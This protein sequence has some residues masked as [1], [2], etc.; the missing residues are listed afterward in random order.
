[1]NFVEIVGELNDELYN[2]FDELE[3]CFSYMTNAASDIIKFEDTI[4]WN[5]EEDDRKYDEEKED[6]EPFI[7]F[8]KQKF[9]DW[10][11][12]INSLKL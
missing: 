6:Y 7:P 4:L 10:A 5:S 1:M 2:E 12:K 8:I 11:D 3:M 9:N